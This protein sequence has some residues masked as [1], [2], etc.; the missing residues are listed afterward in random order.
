V[1]G[2]AVVA[3]VVGLGGLVAVVGAAVGTV[4]VL[5]GTVVVVVVGAAVVLVVVVFSAAAT[6]SPLSS[7][8]EQEAVSRAPTS[9]ATRN[10]W[11][12]VVTSTRVTVL[13]RA[14]VPPPR[15]DGPTLEPQGGPVKV[16]RS[17][18]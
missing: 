5:G 18:A 14:Q 8:P 16:N 10:E 15:R 1:T 11:E 7:P 13:R 6:R 17:D 3:V 2:A 9:N 12:R 4:V